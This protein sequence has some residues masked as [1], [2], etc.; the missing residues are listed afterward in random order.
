MVPPREQYSLNSH[1]AILWNR[2]DIC[3]P[4][5]SLTASPRETGSRIDR[6]E[7]TRVH[8]TGAMYQFL[9]WMSLEG[10]KGGVFPTQ[11]TLVF[12]K[13]GIAHH[14]DHIICH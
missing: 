14:S 10:G 8:S 3:P 5:S 13:L 12:G 6:K 2:V 9:I 4:D 11:K 1:S 7:E